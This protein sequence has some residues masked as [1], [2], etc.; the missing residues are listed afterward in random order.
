MAAIF[1]QWIVCI[2][3]INIVCLTGSNNRLIQDL[4]TRCKYYAVN[5][6]KNG[7]ATHRTC[8]DML[9]FGKD[10]SELFCKIESASFHNFDVYCMER[11]WNLVCNLSIT[12]PISPSIVLKGYFICNSVLCHCMV[13]I[14]HNMQEYTPVLCESHLLFPF[15]FLPPQLSNTLPKLPRLRFLWFICL[16]GVIQTK[17]KDN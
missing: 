13:C 6:S 1:R 11:W 2:G 14:S 7:L 16:F 17:T 3:E 5:L 8:R 4:I 9:H 15:L 10:I 12:A